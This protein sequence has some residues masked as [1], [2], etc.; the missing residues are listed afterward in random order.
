MRIACIHIPQFALQAAN[1]HN[2]QLCGRPVALIS[3][4]AGASVIA[5]SRQAH[6]R[7][8]RAGMSAALARQLGD[9]TIVAESVSTERELVCALAE[10]LCAV[11]PLIDRGG[12]TGPSGLHYALYAEVPSGVRGTT[13][14]SK[15]RAV[16]EQLGISVRIGIADDKFT[17]WA[18]ASQ[19][20]SHT[21][22]TSTSALP[23]VVK[24]TQHRVND[25]TVTSVPRGGSAAF[26]SMM[27]ISM[28]PISS[29]VQHML[30]SLGVTTL[31]AFA[32][33]PEPSGGQR[34]DAGTV[35]LQGLARGDG[36]DPLIAYRA[37]SVLIES[38]AISQDTSAAAAI[39]ILAARIACTLKGREQV[40]AS[41]R[42]IVK[43]KVE[44][45]SEITLFPSV[46]DATTLADR[47]GACLG[48]STGVTEIAVEIVGRTMTQSFDSAASAQ[49]IDT[50][51]VRDPQSTAP[52]ESCE[53]SDDDL[54]PLSTL[55]LLSAPFQTVARTD[56]PHRRIK[57]GKQRSRMDVAAQSRLFG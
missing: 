22:A 12:R 37:R 46:V 40:A 15:A 41:I 30:V 48:E 43:G 6:E 34:A 53:E 31:G 2:P 3:A 1:R 29:E 18:A 35:D 50:G 11:S 39:G 57:R 33:L 55:S 47:F 19:M 42:L 23:G 7:G 17:A 52:T 27:P 14:G 28:L 13:F 38:I 54:L 26:L 25:F 21:K 36:R 16:A 20:R 8:V 24:V 45:T 5:Y 10:S 56:R 9:M 4:V 32:A 51:V 44:R 49:G